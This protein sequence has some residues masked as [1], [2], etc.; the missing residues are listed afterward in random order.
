METGFETLEF[1]KICEKIASC[2]SSDLGNELAF[3]IKPENN[4]DQLLKK[5]N[6]VTELRDILDYDQYPPIDGISDIRSLLKKVRLVGSMLSPHELGQILQN[7]IIVRK[8]EK[9]FSA[10]VDRIPNLKEI[11]SL[12]K[13][14]AAAEK[15]IDRCIDITN[16]TVKDGASPALAGIRRKITRTQNAVRSK[17]AVKLKQFSEQGILQ[18]NVISI[19]D[20]RF[21]LVVKEEYKRKVK[22]LVHGQS[23]SGSSYFIE[24]MD[25]FEDNN[26]IREL[27]TQ[28]TR[29]IEKILFLLTNLLREEINFLESNIYVLGELDL[30]F[31]KAVFSKQ[32]NGNQPELVDEKIIS[33]AQGR[34]P[35]LVLRMGEKQVV[36]L[37]LELGEK[38]YTLIIS[39]PNAGG[40][41]VALKTVG[42]LTLMARCGLHIPALPHSKIGN[43]THIFSCIGDQ[44]SIENDL[45]TFSSHINV[46][47]DIAE[48]A[49]SNS[50]VLVDEIGTGTDPEEGTAIAMSLLED[51][52]SRKCLS[53][54]TTHLGALKAFAFRTE[55][56]ENASLEFDAETLQATYI[57]RVGIPGSSYA[58]DIA[59]RMGYPADLIKKSRELIGTHKDKLEGLILDLEDKVREHKKLTSELKLKETGLKS[60]QKLYTERSEALKRDEKKIKGQAVKEAEEIIS[61]TNS[62]IEKTIKEI[63]EQNARREAIVKAKT[64]IN[65]QKTKIKILKKQTD[66]QKEKIPLISVEPG[67]FVKWKNSNTTGKIISRVDKKGR[68]YIQ[69]N[70]VKMKVPVSELEKSQDT[71]K[72]K[73]LF[74]LNVEEKQIITN[75]VDL[76]GLNAEEAREVVDRFIDEALLTGLKE[77]RIIHGK[78][79]GKL[80]KD[81]SE[82]LKSHR[83]V[84]QF[85]LG[86]W[87]EGDSGVTVVEL[88]S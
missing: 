6:Q 19:R 84:L 88:K 21:V 12:L 36:P 45:S 2:A 30:V 53:V 33:I 55:G 11:T 70:G 56:I 22:G 27:Q 15:E 42:L 46:L 73:S 85:R 66:E 35:L 32:I 54:V 26:Y 40:K 5:H 17:I 82:F 83:Q 18:E 8:L 1:N 44:Q 7:L 47:G 74:K 37:D 67:E 61:Q 71:R 43:I 72:R 41:T 80:R 34:H 28:E 79:T 25:V 24:P 58:F 52:T 20:V 38:F 10:R 65:E 86:Y 68:V 48:H 62:L 81:I 4:L 51:L 23:A 69:L 13:P 87:N 3:A 76:R 39:G 60:I 9:F 75:E 49:D 57:F 16:N 63:K 31:A 59:Q 78:G 64:I 77:I 50:L 14:S 29:E